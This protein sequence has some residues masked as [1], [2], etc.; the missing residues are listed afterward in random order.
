M[1]LKPWSPWTQKEE[2][3]DV[4]TFPTEVGSANDIF[5]LDF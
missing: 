4:D 1:T 3:K 5:L 2:E